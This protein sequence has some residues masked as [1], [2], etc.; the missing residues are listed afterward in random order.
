MKKSER[1][2]TANKKPL[3]EL[4]SIYNKVGGHDINTQVLTTVLYI[5]NE[6][7]SLK[8]ERQYPLHY[9]PSNEILSYKC[10]SICTT[11]IEG[12]LQNSDRGNQRRTK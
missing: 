10:N 12:K 4:I 8:L 7:V 6:L 2:T 11:P 3:Q 9:R 1:I 5:S